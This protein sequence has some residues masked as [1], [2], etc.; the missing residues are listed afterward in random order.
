MKTPSRRDSFLILPVS[1]AEVRSDSCFKLKK[2]RFYA[3]RN[4]KEKNL[5]ITEYVKFLGG[6]KCLDIICAMPEKKAMFYHHTF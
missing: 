1:V 6:N 3:F 5:A 2:V 4:S